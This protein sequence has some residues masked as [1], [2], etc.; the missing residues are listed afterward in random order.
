MRSLA[1]V[2]MV[3]LCGGCAVMVLGP[4]TATTP[5]HGEVLDQ[6][7]CPGS[8]VNDIDGGACHHLFN[9]GGMGPQ[10]GNADDEL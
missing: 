2:M 1:V 8:A 5:C 4:D 7:S 9:C 10:V 6:G 3:L